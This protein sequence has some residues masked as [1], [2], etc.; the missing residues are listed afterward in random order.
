MFPIVS[1]YFQDSIKQSKYIETEDDLSWYEN[2]YSYI[3]YGNKNFYKLADQTNNIMIR[4]AQS[5]SDLIA[6]W[7]AMG[8]NFM[9]KD[10]NFIKPRKAPGAL[11]T[12]ADATSKSV[13]EYLSKKDKKIKSSEFTAYQELATRIDRVL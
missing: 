1:N 3:F 4:I 9:K 11:N 7:N 5:K 13:N 2:I 8:D 6:Q 12:Y 10:P